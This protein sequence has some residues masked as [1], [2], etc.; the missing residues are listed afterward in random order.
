M[1]PQPITLHVDLTCPFSYLALVP[2]E[3]VQQQAPVIVRFV[4]FEVYPEPEPLPSYEDAAVRHW[5][6][7]RVLPLAE[8]LGVPLTLP[9]AWPR[10]RAALAVL[11]Y[12]ERHDVGQLFFRRAAQAYWQEQQDL[13]DPEVLAA[14]AANC[15]LQPRA[16]K[17]V[18]TLGTYDDYVADATARA[19]QLDIVGTPHWNVDGL[20]CEGLPEPRYVLRLLEL[21]RA[22][23]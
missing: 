7:Q 10:T 17:E 22:R 20:V 15:G 19:Q 9:P 23:Q 6:E 16:V 8:R 4:P 18:L 1:G 11:A 12:A 13:A 2:L 5:W 3:Q 21:A 14:L